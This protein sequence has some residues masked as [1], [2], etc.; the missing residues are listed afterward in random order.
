MQNCLTL[1]PT[2]PPPPPPPSPQQ[3][4]HKTRIQH[5]YTNHN[6]TQHNTT[7]HITSPKP[8]FCSGLN[9][10]SLSIYVK[11]SSIFKTFKTIL[12][13]QDEYNIQLQHND[14]LV[15]RLQI[16]L[17]P[18]NSAFSWTS[19]L[20]KIP[21]NEWTHIAVTKT[22]SQ[23]IVSHNGIA[24]QST[25]Y[26][27]AI[28]YT[29][30][31][32]LI[33]SANHNQPYNNDNLAADNN[34]NFVG[35]ID[36]FTVFNSPRFSTNQQITSRSLPLNL[37]DNS[38]NNRDGNKDVAYSLKFDEGR[39][40]LLFSSSSDEPLARPTAFLSTPS[41]ISDVPQSPWRV[42]TAPIDDYVTTDQ[43]MPV[44]ISLNGT[45][46]IHEELAVSL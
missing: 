9:E 5:E 27:N 37:I 12:H 10:F 40:S 39:G 20:P 17:D 8:T 3:K 21:I 32:I 14:T 44:L 1:P 26:N 24:I 11:P 43:D 35:E 7:Q 36:E 19:T 15:S 46:A 42:S 2:P 34:D 33:G 4:Q 22:S 41:T 23:I 45:S 28:P 13:K 30:N 38:V 25:P 16:N 31:P 29:S 6:E 18:S